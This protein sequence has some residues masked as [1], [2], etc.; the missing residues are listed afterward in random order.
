[1]EENP[2][3]CGVVCISHQGDSNLHGKDQPAV[4]T[5]ESNQVTFAMRLDFT[6]LLPMLESSSC[7]S[8]MLLL[9]QPFIA[10]SS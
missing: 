3:G 9:L 1:M 7:Q 2:G 8:T 6:G 5:Q 4:P 10:A